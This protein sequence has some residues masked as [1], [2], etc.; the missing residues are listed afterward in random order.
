M[1]AE[2]YPSMSVTTKN[3]LRMAGATV[4]SGFV[5]T[6]ELQYTR[7]GQQTATV[8]SGA[9]AI[10]VTAAGGVNGAAVAGA[11]S[12]LVMSGGGRLNSFSALFPAGVAL[13]GNGANAIISG[14]PIVV[15]DSGIMAL[16]GIA[17]TATIAASGMKILHVWNP[18]T[19][20]ASGGVMLTPRAPYD[21]V[22]LDIPFFSGLCVLAVSGSPGFTLSYTPQTNPSFG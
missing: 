5:N 7:G 19:L 21:P 10:G 14:Q 16:S 4:N 8:Y 3:P 18:P 13:A 17:T 22:P 20:V 9:I 12:V 6:G 11:G 2:V 15:Y 1:E